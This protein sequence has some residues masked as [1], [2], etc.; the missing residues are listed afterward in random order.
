MTNCEDD[1]ETVDYFSDSEWLRDGVK[2][3]LDKRNQDKIKESTFM[4]QRF[5]KMMDK[6]PTIDDLRKMFQDI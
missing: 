6:I 5:A 3:Y 2:D 4:H 1:D